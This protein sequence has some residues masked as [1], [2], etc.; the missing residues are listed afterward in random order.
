MIRPRIFAATALFLLCSVLLGALDPQDKHSS[1]GRRAAEQTAPFQRPGD[2]V[3]D[4]AECGDCHEDELESIA[5]GTHTKIP[6]ASQLDACET[7]HGPGSEHADENETT[8]IT[9]PAKLAGPAQ[10]AL[11]ARCHG[12]ELADHGGPLGVL[13]AAGKRCSDCHKVHEIHA[14]RPAKKFP[15]L[16]SD[17]DTQDAKAKPVGMPKCVDCHRD[18]TTNLGEHAVLAR[19]RELWKPDWNPDTTCEACHGHGS[20]H[21]ASHGIARLITRPDVVDSGIATC[22][23][24]HSEVDPIE[25]HWKGKKKPLLGTPK[26]AMTCTTCHGIHHQSRPLDLDPGSAPG[27]F[28]AAGPDDATAEGRLRTLPR[29][30]VLRAPRHG[31]PEAGL[32]RL[33]GLHRVPH[34]R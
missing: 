33:E 1:Q 10:K 28:M 12:Y 23:G 2:F 27:T 32:A 5:G 18:K 20:E 11:C 4:A 6:N 19:K 3:R 26:G 15:A 31:P 30:R 21:V 34:R 9:H 25:F 16:F 24:C 8:N 7:C 22:R 14:E 13:L 17:R 29:A